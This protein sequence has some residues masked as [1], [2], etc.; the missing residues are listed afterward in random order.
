ME[1]TFPYPFAPLNVPERSTRPENATAG[2]PR[3]ETG[4]MS[5]FRSACDQELVTFGAAAGDTAGVVT[6]SS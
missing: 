4:G 3:R 5:G 6:K 1:R 2:L